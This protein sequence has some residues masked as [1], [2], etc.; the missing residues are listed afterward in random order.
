MPTRREFLKRSITAGAVAAAGLAGFSLYEPHQLKITRLELSLRRLP[1]AWDGVR[2]AQVSDL[3]FRPFTTAGEI[4]A[5]VRAVNSLQPDLIALTGDFVTI[6]MFGDS[7]AAARNM[8]VCAPLLAALRA[9]LGV[10]AVLGNHDVGTDPIFIAGALHDRGIEVLRNRALPLERG[11]ARVWIAGLD[12]AENNLLDIPRALA[13]V[14]DEAAVILMVHEP[15]VADQAARYAVDLQLSG[16]SHGGQIAVPLLGPP[17][18][19]PLARKYWRGLYRVRDLQVYTNR[20]IG[21]VGVPMRFQAPP[22]ITL[23]TLRSPR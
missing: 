6:P 18:L 17:Y 8:E 19:P 7:V 12:D 4:E 3:H 22:E 11:G 10:V 13:P 16:H 5:A 23:F 20:G 14:R 21:T 1:P 9:P 2:V 15:D